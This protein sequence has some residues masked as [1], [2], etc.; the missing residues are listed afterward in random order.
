MHAH[1][2]KH[3]Y[4]VASRYPHHCHWCSSLRDEAAFINSGFS[5]IEK[6]ASESLQQAMLNLLGNDEEEKFVRVNVGAMGEIRLSVLVRHPE[7]GINDENDALESE[8]REP[9]SS[10]T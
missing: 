6:A 9:N 5:E 8:E 10:S 7:D 2:A 3:G 1:A 4:L